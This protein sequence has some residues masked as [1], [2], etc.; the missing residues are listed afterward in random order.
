MELGKRAPTPIREKEVTLCM[1]CQEP[2][3]SITK[4]RHHC[5]ACGHVRSTPPLPSPPDA[6]SDRLSSLFQVV[7]G[8]CSEF[9]ARLSYDNNRTNRVCV[10]CYVTL[11]GVSPSLGGPSGSQRRRSILEVSVTDEDVSASLLL[12][13]DCLLFV[14]IE[15]GVAGSR[16]QRDV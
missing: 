8:K 13:A 1:K 14:T 9:R 12:D 5:K 11:V 4:R 15:T 3:N 2:F 16:E 10:D 6:V 7:C